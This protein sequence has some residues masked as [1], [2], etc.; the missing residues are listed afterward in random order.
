MKVDTAS[1]LAKAKREIKVL[2]YELTQIVTTANDRKNTIVPNSLMD[3]EVMEDTLM[4]YKLPSR[5]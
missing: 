2:N 3:I 1:T 4:T 5:H